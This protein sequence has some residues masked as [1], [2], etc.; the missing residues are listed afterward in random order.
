ML[1][2]IWK[3]WLTSAISVFLIDVC[4]TT[5]T[6]KFCGHCSADRGSRMLISMLNVWLSRVYGMLWHTSLP[7]YSTR[8]L[9]FC[10]CRWPCKRAWALKYAQVYYY[11]HCI[12]FLILLEAFGVPAGFQVLYDVQRQLRVAR[13]LHRLTQ[14]FACFVHQVR[15]RIVFIISSRLLA[16]KCI[17]FW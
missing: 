5:W 4:S 11:V 10:R 17:I 2:S 14:Q 6:L 16:R 13:R 9:T 15:L 1:F 3:F 8:K 12:F 7:L